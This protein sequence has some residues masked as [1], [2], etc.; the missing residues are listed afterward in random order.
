M[1]KCDKTHIGPQ[2]AHTYTCN[3]PTMRSEVRKEKEDASRGDKYFGWFF[4]N[5]REGISIIQRCWSAEVQFNSSQLDLRAKI[6]LHAPVSKI[7]QKFETFGQLRLPKPIK[8]LQEK[9]LLKYKCS[10]PEVKESFRLAKSTY[11]A[12]FKVSVILE[13]IQ[14]ATG[15][16]RSKPSSLSTVMVVSNIY[17]TV[18][19]YP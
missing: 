16:R 7:W 6:R 13:P 18:S 2:C 19:F 17:P 5:E 12:W 8:T 9:A 11:F 10:Q 15:C 14:E 3:T 4:K 1:I